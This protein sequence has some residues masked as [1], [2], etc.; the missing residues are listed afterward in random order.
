[1]PDTTSYLYLGLTVVTVI[2]GGYI[3]SVIIRFRSAFKD[4]QLLEQL[5]ED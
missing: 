3:G 2:L 5:A 4:V 1:M